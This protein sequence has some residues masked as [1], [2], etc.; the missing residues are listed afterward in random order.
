MKKYVRRGL[1]ALFSIVFVIGLVG[2]S[3]QLIGYHQ[4]A[5]DYSDAEELAKPPAEPEPTPE[6]T[7]PADSG[8][9]EEE[10]AVPAEVLEALS[11]VDL[12]ALQEVNPEV[13]GWILIPNT[14]LDYPMVQGTDNDYYLNHTWKRSRN[15]MGAIFLDYRC[16]GDLLDDNTVIYGHRMNNDS[17][18][19]LLHQYKSQHYFDEHPDIYIVDGTGCYRYAIFAAYE[20]D[21]NGGKTYI[22]RFSSNEKKLEYLDYC[23]GMSVIDAGF[24]PGVDQRVITLSTC[25][26]NGHETRWVVQA[27][28]QEAVPL[29]KPMLESEVSAEET[30]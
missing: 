1:L 5:Q 12:T 19:G 10:P 18:F 20:A 11:Q 9:E 17:M 23:L 2:L 29:E 8:L 7:L 3:W 27:V 13:L 30:I 16:G 26:G 14:G 24:V 21:A 6:I 25:T 4:G 28:L 15:S 22:V